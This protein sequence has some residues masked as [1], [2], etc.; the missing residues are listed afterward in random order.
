M[1]NTNYF[2]IEDD[3]RSMKGATVC[4]TMLDSNLNSYTVG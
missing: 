2:V 4:Y 3:Y 1:T